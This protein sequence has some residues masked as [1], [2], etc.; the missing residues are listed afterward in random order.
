MS[1]AIV[2]KSIEDLYKLIGKKEFE[3]FLRLKN[4]KYK[5]FTKILIDQVQPNNKEDLVKLQKAVNGLLK[6]SEELTKTINGTQTAILNLTNIAKISQT[7]AIFNSVIGVMNLCTTAAGFAMVMNKLNVIQNQIDDVIQNQLK[8]HEAEMKYKFENVVSDYEELLD[9][10]NGGIPFDESRLIALI[11]KE[12]AVLN[13]MISGFND[14]LVTDSISLLQGIIALSSM[15]SYTICKYDSVYYFNHPEKHGFYG[16]HQQWV[17]MYDVL[18]SEQFKSRLQDLFFIEEDR[19][20]N[21]TD[22]LAASVFDEFKDAKETILTQ[23]E[24][25]QTFDSM[26]NYQEAMRVLDESVENDIEDILHQNNL[27]IDKIA[28]AMVG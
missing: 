8:I 24:I 7:L 20:Q 22:A 25:I 3:C 19:N 15:F 16:F 9:G 27:H 21:V 14:S 1:E 17:D 11:K 6:K 26:K 13:Y 23:V 28:L 12:K 5:K 10:E 18:M 2:V 4:G